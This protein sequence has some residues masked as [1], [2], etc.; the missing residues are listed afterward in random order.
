[1]IP[2]T[3][4][5]PH[6]TAIQIARCAKTTGAYTELVSIGPRL[7]QILMSFPRKRESSQP[8]IN[9]LL[10]WPQCLIEPRVCKYSIILEVNPSVI[11]QVHLEPVKHQM[12][13]IAVARRIS[14]D[15]A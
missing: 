15:G 9:A 3:G 2:I 4:V 1:M 10:L 14:S 12:A 5:V 6:G 11:M 8:Y 7:V 13:V